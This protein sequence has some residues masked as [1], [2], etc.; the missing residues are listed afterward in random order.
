[1]DDLKDFDVNELRISSDEIKEYDTG[2]PYPSYEPIQL[3]S[4]GSLV[5]RILGNQLSGNHLFI[6]PMEN[7]SY[8]LLRKSPFHFSNGKLLIY[9]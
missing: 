6:F 1:M 8:K 5:L 4:V 2:K 9:N 3:R 7:Y